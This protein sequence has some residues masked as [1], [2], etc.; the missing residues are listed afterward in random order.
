MQ[1]LKAHGVHL[2][3]FKLHRIHGKQEVV[4]FGVGDG[5]S[6]CIKLLFFAPTKI[7]TFWYLSAPHLI[8]QP[9]ILC[10]GTQD[11]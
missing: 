8:F 11:S 6:V 1:A 4:Q 5:A 7:K 3:K 9:L 2:L 10:A